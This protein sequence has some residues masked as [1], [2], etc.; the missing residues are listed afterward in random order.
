MKRLSG[1]PRVVCGAVVLLV[2][3]VL[4]IEVHAARKPS[5]LAHVSC[6]HVGHL[7]VLKTHKQCMVS[8]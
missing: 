2:G 3:L 8:T 1:S 5:K 6:K 4:A 7:K